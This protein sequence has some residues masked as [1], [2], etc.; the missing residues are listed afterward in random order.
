VPHNRNPH[1]T[2][3]DRVLELLARAL[4][5]NDPRTRRQVLHG[6]GGVGK[7]HVALEYAYRH[8]EEYDLVWWLPAQDDAGLA[9]RLLAAVRALGAQAA[10][11]RHAGRA[12]R[13]EL[14]ARLARYG[15]WL[16]VFDNAPGAEQ[17][18]AYLPAPATAGR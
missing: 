11:R 8:R 9:V 3:R 7:T 2:G 13:I 4:D 12:A 1:F 6:V 14:E 5:G 18:Q 10:G 15:R 17:V 16:L